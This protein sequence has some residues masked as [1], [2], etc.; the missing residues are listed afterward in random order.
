MKVR[1]V[2]SYE[3]KVHLFTWNVV[4]FTLSIRHQFTRRVVTFTLGQKY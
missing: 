3:K 4:E 1:N 2:P